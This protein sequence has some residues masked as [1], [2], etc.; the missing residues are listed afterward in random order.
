[1]RFTDIFIERPVLATVVSLLIFVLGM[2]SLL[3]LPIRQ[4]PYTETAVIT[5]TT[6]YTGAD[7]S[8]VAG[9]ITTPLENSI[10][11][12]NGIDYMV[13]NS[14]ASTSTITIY[15]QLNY[16]ANKALSE[17]NTKVNA[18][19]NQLPK[20]SQ[21]PVVTIASAESIDS[22]YMGFYSTILPNNKIT[23]Y[24]I[25]VVQPKIQAVNGVQTAEIIGNRQ[26]AM[27]AWLDP[28]KLA[29]YHITATDVSNALAS[30]DFISAIGRTDGNMVTADLTATTGLSSVKEFRN[31]VLKSQNGVIVRLGDVAKVSLG[32]I[33]YDTAVSFNAQRAVYVGLVVAPTANLLTVMNNVKKIFP[34][35]QQ[36]LP[37]G[38][39]AKIVYDTTDYVNSSIHEVVKSLSEAIVIVTLV[40]FLFLGS[41]RSVIIPVIAI[42][43][44]LIGAFFIMLLLQYSINLLTLLA[45]VL[46]I[47]LVVDDAIIVVENVHRHIENRMSKVEAA[48]QGAR[49]LANPIIAI[50]VVLIAV[51]VPIGFMGGLTGALFTEFAFTLAGAV[52]ISAIVALTLSP[53]MCSKVLGL[54]HHKSRFITFVDDQ[55]EKLRLHYQYWLHD[56]LE[57]LPVTAVFALIVLGSIYFLYSTSPVELAPQE[58]Q[59][60]IIAQLTAAPNAALPQ[61]QL[62]QK[63]V[64]KIFN[65]LPEK[66][67]IFQLDGIGGLNAGI[68]GVGLKPWEQRVRTTMEIQPELQEKFNQ[69]SGAKVVAF[70]PPPLPGGGR[71]LPIQFVLQT[72][73]S[74]DRLNLLAQQLIDQAQK[75]GEFMYLDS[76][77]K[78][79]KAQTHIIL[80]RD[81]IAEF[82][83]TMQSVGDAL[84]SAL[85]Q[86]YI[87]YFNF[88]GRSY[89]V[90]PQVNRSE[91]INSKQLLDY[92]IT[93]ANGVAIPLSTVAKM[94]TTTVPE[95]LN[96]FQQ[97]NSATISAIA[98]PGVTMGQALGTLKT[99]ANQ[100]LP[101]GYTV[102]YAGQSRQYAQEGNA[103]VET[104]FFAIIII[105]LSLAALFE[106]FRDPLIVLISVPMSICGAMIFISL[107]VKGATLNIY[108]EVGL[109]TLIGLISK[110]G[111]LIVQFANDLQREGKSKREAVEMAAGIRLR[112][113]LM[114]TASMVLGVIP[115]IL[116]TGAGA[117]SRFDIGLVISTGIAIGTL[118]TLFVVPAMYLFLAETHVRHHESH[119]L[120]LGSESAN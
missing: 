56:S 17:I 18:V 21:L 31:L 51:Y 77:L 28:V 34:E 33:N 25:R 96:H 72:T 117:V 106:S 40:I 89:Q 36:E 27:R 44:S 24:L 52:G 79:D 8:V 63:E 76:D 37:Q 10:A 99:L 104:F 45:L 6:T 12:S 50:S 100:I 88:D 109:V 20:N 54:N 67:R 7:P 86:G 66:D 78:I 90:I 110:H 71:G 48:I 113:I 115:L 74:F 38:L 60:I 75:S 62:Y 5:V 83:L 49:E 81:K 13:S 1:M 116:A 29:A 55:F 46:G 108:T 95:S 19:L 98:M 102:E 103:L 26:F 68:S 84:G 30:N 43:L 111:I 105:F 70:Q 4:Y 69:I 61:T 11:Q 65:Q 64:Y 14:T 59:G 16:D 42:P 101:P 80:D 23:D 93:T 73:E 39:D 119:E 82:G 91:R 94:K 32:S 97:M 118:F 58:D 15:L 112:P 87:N 53:M 92:Y 114:T 57:Y 41:I 22:M 35:I 3:S 107:G 9:F 47:G 85:S 120:D 2:R